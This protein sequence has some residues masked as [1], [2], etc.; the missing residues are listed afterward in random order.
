MAGTSLP[1]TSPMRWM[2]PMITTPTSA[3]TIS[4]VIQVG[5][6]KLPASAVA[7]ELTCTALP[8]PKAATAP[9]TANP[10]PSHLPSSGANAPTPLR[11]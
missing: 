9:N 10:N 5:T 4:P 1:A 2:P 7:M 6:P 3:A 11:R 8:M